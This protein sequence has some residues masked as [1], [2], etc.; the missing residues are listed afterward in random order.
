MVDGG[1]WRSSDIAWVALFAVL[2]FA[3]YVMLAPLGVVL[4][5]LLAPFILGVIGGVLQGERGAVNASVATLL[6]WL[7]SLTATLVAHGFLL[8]SPGKLGMVK[9]VAL[10]M[11][12]ITGAILVIDML[13]SMSLAYLGGWL[14][15]RMGWCRR[16]EKWGEV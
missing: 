6:V 11:P 16:C 15:V 9:G 12:L 5:M 4:D 1:H 7:A 8:P 3:L 14:A 13:L 2:L 10:V